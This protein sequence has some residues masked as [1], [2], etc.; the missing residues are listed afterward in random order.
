[1]LAL[2]DYNHRTKQESNTKLA[3]HIYMDPHYGRKVTPTFSNVMLHER[4]KLFVLQLQANGA[5]RPLQNLH[6]SLPLV[7]VLKCL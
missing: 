5:T 6:N 4:L 1:M 3:M 7:S 2:T